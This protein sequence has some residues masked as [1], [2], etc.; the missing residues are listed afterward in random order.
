MEKT[1]AQ[2][3]V[4]GLV[5]QG[6]ELVFG[7]PGSHVNAL[8]PLLAA[9]S[10]RHIT[11]KHEN[12]G[13]M[14]ADVY[15]RLTGK[16]GI[17]IT[18]AGPGATNAITGISGAYSA[19]SPLVHLSG[20]VPRGAKK[21]GFHGASAEGY[22]QKMFEPI[23]LWSV[24]IE[25]LGELPKVLSKAFE[26][27]TSRER[28]GPVHIEI[29]WDLFKAGRSK[30]DES[31][32]VGS[33]SYEDEKNAPCLASMIKILE[34]TS[35][36]LICAGKGVV[37]QGA[38]RLLQQ[39]AERMQIPVVTSGSTS[40]IFAEDHPLFAGFVADFL[41][42][43]VAI[44]TLE[45]AEVLLMIGF[46]A[47]TED[48][49]LIHQYA[50][51]RLLF[52]G[53][54]SFD[55]IDP[56]A[57]MGWVGN[58]HWALGKM[59]SLSVKT[60]PRIG[61]DL[62]KEMEDYK[63]D[64]DLWVEGYRASDPLYFGI[65][66]KELAP[67]LGRETICITDVGNHGILARNLLPLYT[68]APMVQPGSYGAMGFAIPG[69]IGAK[70]ARPEKQVVGITGDGCFLLSFSDFL[71]AVELKLPLVWILLNDSHFGMIRYLHVLRFGK[72]Y[73]S[74]I[75]PVD[76]VKLAESFGGDGFRVKELSE[77]RPA[78]EKAFSTLVPTIVEIVTGADF[79][80]PPFEGRGR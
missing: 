76:F 63:K 66:L 41:P 34:Q 67:F 65:V 17:L 48:L 11:V 18:T 36:P 40:G 71:T 74:E 56:K 9:T 68:H 50:K 58:S 69:A 29:P 3:I 30:M 2:A 52:I 14:M 47:E 60:R 23:T 10:I 25:H 28:P 20:S 5:E 26:L 13:A 42:H 72:S 21:E 22:L 73:A 32:W 43:P 53:F 54:D 1:A 75:G 15:G 39:F 45:K 57:E 27:S 16:P 78:L 12:N 55:R 51:G 61:L 49:E 24:R 35:F 80:Y 6:V 62:S 31:P 4:D 33:E 37:V 7:M 44:R 77:L 64:L 19:A 79:P 8:Y 46:G 38:E 70:L 59:L